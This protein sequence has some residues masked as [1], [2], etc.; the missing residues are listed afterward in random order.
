MPK[1]RFCNKEIKGKGFWCGPK[2]LGL[3]YCNIGCYY[4]AMHRDYPYL[5]NENQHLKEGENN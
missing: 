2:R 1:C 3:C 5:F 4:A